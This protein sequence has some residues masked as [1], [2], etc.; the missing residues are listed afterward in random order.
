MKHISQKDIRDGTGFSL[1][2]GTS[3]YADHSR[4]KASNLRSPHSHSYF[5]IELVSRGECTQSINGKEYVCT[6]GT[7]S[8]LSPLDNHLYNIENGAE[9]YY[10]IFQESMVARS[11]WSKVT[12]ECTPYIL[13]LESKE[14]E[15]IKR[16]LDMLCELTNTRSEIDLC[17]AENIISRI[18]IY[19]LKG[20]G[21]DD[22]PHKADNTISRAISYIRKNFKE[23][24]TL[25]DIAAYMNMDYNYFCRYF[26]KHMGV[27]F[28][29]YLLER[30]LAYAANQLLATNDTVTEI[31]ADCGFDSESHFYSTFKKKYGASPDQF[32]K[33]NIKGD[34]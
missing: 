8:L 18:V 1:E 26:K 6:P 2:P 7:I 22:L 21:G 5:S 17:L 12:Y 32:R 29:K 28:K 4:Y 3:F 15:E 19:I 13:K 34:T 25:S 23:N 30:R 14:F 31:Y 16:D 9:L 11:V 27:S 20:V 33:Q 24:I 10:L